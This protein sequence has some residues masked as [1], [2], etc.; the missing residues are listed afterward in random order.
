M[1]LLE[2]ES[3]KIQSFVA[4]K[5]LYLQRRSQTSVCQSRIAKQAFTSFILA[6]YVHNINPKHGSALN[7]RNGLIRSI[8]NV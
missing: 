7:T 1:N 3:L 8:L 4:S 6:R 2:V 5:K